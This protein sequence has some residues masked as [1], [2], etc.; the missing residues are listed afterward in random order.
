[1]QL[2]SEE[3]IEIRVDLRTKSMSVTEELSRF[4]AEDTLWFLKGHCCGA[5]Q[6]GVT[7][8]IPCLRCFCLPKHSPTSLPHREL[9]LAPTAQPSSWGVPQGLLPQQGEVWGAGSWSVEKKQGR[10]LFLS[11]GK[12]CYFHG[13]FLSWW[14]ATFTLL[15]EKLAWFPPKISLRAKKC[16]GVECLLQA[17]QSRSSCT[18]PPSPPGLSLPQSYSCRH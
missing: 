9:D 12:C 4:R 7:L 10:K 3:A 5:E 1:M 17:A 14:T 6:W 18:A 15:K 2:K 11:C 8:N 16:F 13:N